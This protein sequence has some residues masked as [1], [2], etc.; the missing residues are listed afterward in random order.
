MMVTRKMYRRLEDL[1]GQYVPR[2]EQHV[3]TVQFVDADKRVV[4][5]WKHTV[6]ATPG[7]KRWLFGRNAR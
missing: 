2:A 1:E 4:E 3:I 7:W 5:E 6:A